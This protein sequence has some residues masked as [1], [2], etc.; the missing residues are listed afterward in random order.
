MALDKGDELT[1]SYL[2]ATSLSHFVTGSRGLEMLPLWEDEDLLKS[3]AVR[4][5]KLQ[6]WHLSQ[7]VMRLLH[8]LAKLGRSFSQTIFGYGTCRLLRI[9]VWKAV[10]VSRESCRQ[11]CQPESNTLGHEHYQVVMNVQ[12]WNSNSSI[13]G[14]SCGNRHKTLSQQSLLHQ[15]HDTPKTTVQNHAATESTGLFLVVYYTP[16]STL[17]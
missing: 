9:T 12:N 6:N 11:R 2:Q 4:Q 1:I 14:T 7:N 17:V 15:N 8:V 3:T 13:S 10:E 16:F 5:Q